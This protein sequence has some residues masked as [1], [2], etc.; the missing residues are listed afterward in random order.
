MTKLS[1]RGWFKSRIIS[2]ALHGLIAIKLADWFI[3]R[4]G[5]SHD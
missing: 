5:L 4:G 3:Q 2:A 1:I